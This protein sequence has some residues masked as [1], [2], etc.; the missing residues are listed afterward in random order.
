MKGLRG[1]PCE[2][3][4]VVT[5]M[6]TVS[7]LIWAGTGFDRARAETAFCSKTADL[8][9]RACNLEVR[10]DYLGARAVC[11]NVSDAEARDT[12]RDEAQEARNETQEECN[13]QFE[14]RIDVCGLL[15]EKRYD[16]D[17]SPANFVDPNEIGKSI[18]PNPYF[19]L[20]P[21]TR[22]V[23]EGGEELITVVVTDKTKLIEGVICRVVNDLVV[24][25]GEPVEDTDDWYAQDLD[26][27]VWYCGEEVK[28][29]E[30]FEGD[31][32]ER[33]ELVSIDGSFK[34]GREGAKAGFL[35]LANPNVGDAYR[36]EYF[37]GE[38]EDAVEVLSVTGTESV[39][40]VNCNGTCLVTRDFTPL[41][42]NVEENKYYAP[43]VG[44][45]LEVDEEGNRTEL[46]EFHQP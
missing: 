19:P 20:I 31:D 24:E 26:G 3:I 9:R 30:N 43:G 33:P 35:V 15:G 16:P 17:F 41:D 7:S 11:L 1:F 13:A 38:A 8:Q 2:K 22:W 10:E 28:D 39:P 27:N 25:D 6:M 45:I 36:Q 40:A 5:M 21:G 44:P 46:V 32:P 37:Q 12:C 14:A 29:F 34:V 42:P 23:Y 18:E 4:A